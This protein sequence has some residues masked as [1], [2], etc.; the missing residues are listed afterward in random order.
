MAY[1]QRDYDNEGVYQ[2]G[3]HG[4]NCGCSNCLNETDNMPIDMDRTYEAVHSKG[5]GKGKK[6]VNKK[7][8]FSGGCDGC[9]CEVCAL[10]AGFFDWIANLVPEL[11]GNVPILGSILKPVANATLDALDPYRKNPRNPKQ[12]EY[13]PTKFQPVANKFTAPQIATINRLNTG[14]R[15]RGLPKKGSMAA[16]DKMA[17][18]RSLRKIN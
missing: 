5:K 9:G 6:K 17:Y 7:V 8:K 15:G 16:M 11:V 13:V 12:V 18:L 14:S 10:G 3:Y 1:I 2:I 4:G